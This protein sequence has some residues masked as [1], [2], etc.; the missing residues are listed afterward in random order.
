MQSNL[1]TGD[2]NFELI[3]DF[4]PIVNSTQPIPKVSI[5]GGQVQLPVL[6][7]KSAMQV[8]LSSSIADVTFSENPVYEQKTVTVTIPA[9]QVQVHLVTEN[10]NML[11]TE[12]RNEL[13]TEGAVNRVIDVRLVTT[14][15][16]GTSSTE[17]VYIIQG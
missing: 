13:T 16:D 11:A 9:E 5:L 6:M 17:Y 3:L 12:D 10:G 7:Q 14:Y 1:N 4:R 15:A 8:D 2:V